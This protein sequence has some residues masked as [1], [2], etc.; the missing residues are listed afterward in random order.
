MQL[1]VAVSIDGS[2]VLCSGSG[3]ARIHTLNLS[4]NNIGDKGA[5]ALAEMLKVSTHAWPDFPLAL[6]AHLPVAVL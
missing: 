2:Q 1:H 6:V 4:A 5:A 3:D